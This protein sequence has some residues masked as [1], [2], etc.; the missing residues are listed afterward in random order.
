VTDQARV[1]EKRSVTEQSGARQNKAE[2]VKE[3][4]CGAWRNKVRDGKRS[5]TEQSACDGIERV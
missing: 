2:D 1:T 5:V 4:V 3:D